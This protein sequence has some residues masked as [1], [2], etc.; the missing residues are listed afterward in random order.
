M[1]NVIIFQD[2][3][4]EK[5]Y[6]HDWKQDELF[7]YFKAQI[8]N[9]IRLGWQP[10]DIIIGTN[11]DFSYKEVTIIKLND[12]CQYNKYFNKQYGIEIRTFTKSYLYKNNELGNKKE[13]D[14]NLIS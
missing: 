11:L 10:K 9:S 8:D 3:I 1:K 14:Y 5:T 4:R 7:A 13:I 6:G 2:W 12:I